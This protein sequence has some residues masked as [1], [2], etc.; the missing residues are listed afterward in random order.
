MISVNK[1]KTIIGDNIKYLGFETILLKNAGNRV[2]A[3]D[4]TATFPMPLFNNSAMD[5]FAVRAVDT[6]G[7]K[8]T[9][10]I[11]LI[12]VGVSSAGIPSKI[13]LK[14]GQC[15][16]CMTGGKI[17]KGADSIVIVE[18][19]SGFSNSKTVEIFKEAKIGNHIRKKGEE[20]KQGDVIISK[21]TCVTP[22]E[23]G[24]LATFG[25]KKISVTIRPKVAI[26]VTGNELVE[27]G[28]KIKL[29]Q[30]YNSNLYILVELAKKSG[31]E[32][33]MMETIKDDKNSLSKSLS[34]ALKTCNIIIS[35]GGIS[36][37][38][39]DYVREVYN[40]LGV[41]EHFWKVA[42]KPGKPLFFGT[43]ES[44]LIFGLPGNPVSSFICFIEYVYPVMQELQRK[45]INFKHYAILTESFPAENN[46][47]RY[48]FGR[49]WINSDGKIL[50]A[51]SS[52]SGSHMI[53]SSL[54]SNCILES[55]P[56]NKNLK[57]GDK[58]TINLLNWRNIE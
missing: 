14:P 46:K 4:I 42:Q 48:L 11:K 34:K 54:E 30:I 7:A 6:K 35:S 15:I 3:Q 9:S 8:K 10:P 22:N 45:K 39:F 19:S 43:V 40:K 29:G 5:G 13:I 33:V 58:I 27:P 17:P 12:M 18:N 51:P 2:N 31:V 32:I 24:A 16:Q 55:P 47:H 57:P 25:Y 38:R 36:M 21:N 52:K 23:I 44:T 26:F 41:N 37:G 20:I 1:A 56:K 53:T 50:C 28:D 49:S